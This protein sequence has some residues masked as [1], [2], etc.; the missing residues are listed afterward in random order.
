MKS[1]E[2]DRNPQA[3]K[4]R[5]AF[6]CLQVGLRWLIAIYRA[7][8][9]VRTKLIPIFTLLLV[10]SLYAA[11]ESKPQPKITMEQAKATVLQKESGSIKSSELEKGHGR[12]IYSFDVATTDGVHEVNVDANTGKV[13]EDSKETAPQE[14]K[15]AAQKHNEHQKNQDETPN[16]Q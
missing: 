2:V 1:S 5:P 16:P 13:V 15:E 7:G 3:H 10:L 11:A 8:G 6:A 4:S 14:A 12:W 9:D